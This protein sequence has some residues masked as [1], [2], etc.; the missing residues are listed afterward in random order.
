MAKYGQELPP[1]Y[2]LRNVTAPFA[3]FYAQND[4]LAGPEDVALLFDQLHRTAI[5]MFKVPFEQFNHVDFLWGKDAPSLVY[6]KVLEVMA[7][8]A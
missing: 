8:F 2:D 7:R 6:T 1:H 4:W 3:L 5:G